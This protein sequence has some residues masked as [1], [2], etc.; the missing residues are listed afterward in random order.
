MIPPR[1]ANH[2]L[3]FGAMIAVGLNLRGPIV[4]VAPVLDD[5]R[6]ELRITETEAGLLTS[7]PV[8]CFAVVS[9]FVAGLARRIGS[10]ATVAVSMA[11][12]TL[13]LA[14]RPW[15]GFA[16]MLAGTVLMGAAIAGDNV[17]LPAIARRDFATRPGPVLS[18]VTTSLLVSASIPAVL[19]VPL[20][21]IVGWRAAL[22]V[23][24]VMASVAL[25]IWWLATGLV[26]G[27]AAAP[28][29]RDGNGTDDGAHPGAHTPPLPSA[30]RVPAAWTLG[31]FFGIQALMFYATTAW[32][33]TMLQAYGN[34]DAAAAG[35]A[36]SLFQLLG[37]AGAVTVPML[38]RG[39]RLRYGVA[40]VVAALW[41]VLFACLLLA[42][43]AWPLWC[44]LGGVAQ[45]GGIGLGLSLIAIRSSGGAAARTV[46]AMVQTLG[47]CLG[48][49]GPVLIGGLAAATT[50]WRAPFSVLIVLSALL[51]A[52]GVKAAAPRHIL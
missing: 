21:S 13:A 24:A 35:T 45:G 37:I 7:V 12:L 16:L 22:S 51:G 9:P 27:R 43:G 11:A 49:L 46:S 4:A 1:L 34:L 14:V 48:A 42:P 32:L 15:G 31:L 18:A 44:A 41:M 29:A 52:L 10:N 33:P 23:W 50:G 39:P 38:I 26:T 47:Y 5:V 2:W 17:L 6:R 20:A 3:Q 36:L 30:W 28:T 40:I 8:L 19:M 25:A